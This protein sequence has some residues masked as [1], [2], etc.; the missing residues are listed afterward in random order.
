[1]GVGGVSPQFYS[2][3]RIRDRFA[4]NDGNILEYALIF[5]LEK[6]VED[7]TSSSCG[8]LDAAALCPEKGNETDGESREEAIW[9]AA[10]GSWDCLACRNGGSKETLMLFTAAWKEAVTRCHSVSSPR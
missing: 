9:G 7:W 8:N 2:L 3:F 5:C 1:M 4:K 10:E 6:A